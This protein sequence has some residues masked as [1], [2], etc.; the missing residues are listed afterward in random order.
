M[1]QVTSPLVTLRSG[2]MQL[3]VVPD[4]GGSI[5]QFTSEHRGR[6]FDWMRPASQN[7]L[8]NRSAGGTSSFPMVPFSNRIRNGRFQF[9]G[10]TIQLEQNFRPEPHAIHG[11][12][13]RQPWRIVDSSNTSLIIE[14]QHTADSWPWRYRA[15][16]TFHLTNEQLTV[17]FSVTNESKDDMPVGFGLH[18]Y[19][20][21]TAGSTIRANVGD[22]WRA[23]NNA[24]PETLVAP[25]EQ[26]LL[27]GTGLKPD[28]S[29]LDNNFVDFGGQVQIDW[30]ERRARL[31][32]NADPI[33]Q[34]LVVYTPSE[35][36]FFCVEPATNHIDGF[37]LAAEGRD[38]TGIIVVEPND[39]AIGNVT[40]TPRSL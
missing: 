18:P 24:M 16:Q 22:M 19:F 33:Y 34:C 5:S 2:T 3:T 17:R 23:D 32:I 4:V 20:V 26:L 13:W 30:P 9:R 12:A 6:M 25:P 38:G 1:R 10:R 27:D 21:R 28:A 31:E 36:P 37:N 8:T 7:A 11:H 40:F 35:Q 39:T 29:P 15:Q 14:Y